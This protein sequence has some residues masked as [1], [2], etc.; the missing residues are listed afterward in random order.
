M[1]NIGRFVKNRV[2][3]VVTVVS[4]I[5]FT[6]L[7]FLYLDQHVAGFRRVDGPSMSP[8]LNKDEYTV[9]KFKDINDFT[10]ARDYMN[11]PDYVYFTRK[12]DLGRGDVVILEDPKSKNNFLC[13]RVVALAGDQIVPL[14]FNNKR[15]D[16]VK[17]KEGEVWVESDAGFGYK[18]SNLLGPVRAETIQGKVWWATQPFPHMW[19]THTRNIQSEVSVETLARVTVSEQ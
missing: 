12:F 19:L 4:G 10:A 6:G 9:E 7:G 5:A 16:P 11:K 15:K 2:K 13:K 18:D 14:G 17:L 3:D 1:S 8:T